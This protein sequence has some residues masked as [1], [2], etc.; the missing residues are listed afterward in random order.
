MRGRAAAAFAVL[1]LL[2]PLVL[3]AKL[4]NPSPEERGLFFGQYLILSAGAPG[5]YV[6]G[7]FD[8]LLLMHVND[9]LTFRMRGEGCRLGSYN[10]TIAHL[11]TGERFS[12]EARGALAGRFPTF[13]APREGVYLLEIS[14]AAAVS[15]GRTCTVAAE[16]S[17]AAGDRGGYAKLFTLQAW[18]GAAL[19]ASAAAALYALGRRRRQRFAPSELG[20]PEGLRGRLARLEW[21]FGF[22]GLWVAS[23]LVF[24]VYLSLFDRFKLSIP[25]REG[26]MPRVELA[27]L[28]L[29]SSASS[30]VEP[31]VAALHALLLVSVL[32]CY[33]REEGYEYVR[34]LLG[35]TPARGYLAKLL[36]Y[37]V[38]TSLPLVSAKAYLILSWDAALVFGN[39]LQFLAT[40]GRVWVNAMLFF[41]YLL[42]F[43]SLLS[44]LLPRT[45]YLLFAAS[46]ELYVYETALGGPL[47][48]YPVYRQLVVDVAE[49]TS[50]VAAFWPHFAAA[51]AA[52]L[53]SFYLHVRRGEVKWR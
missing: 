43:Y 32:Y 21:Y 33:S 1:A 50:V 8:Q 35:V 11:S 5:G 31:V 51:L 24:L 16:F 3:L 49:A 17:A 6:S 45:L 28:L 20:S 2:V 13:T 46:I 36:T 47:M 25:Q 4:H 12:I 15:G 23:F 41:M 34:F 48:L 22:S 10:V 27:F 40:V 44:Y 7:S 29:A 42:A 37:L 26:L 18:V 53:A 9:T 19:T 30:R 39:P 52:G 38:L 14:V